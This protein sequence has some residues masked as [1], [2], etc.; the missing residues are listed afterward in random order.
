M[1]VSVANT[2]VHLIYI[3][4]FVTKSSQT[5]LVVSVKQVVDT[6]QTIADK[7]SDSE[8]GTNDNDSNDRIEWCDLRFFNLLTA[9]NCLQLVCSGGQGAIMCN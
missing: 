8:V 2:V 5:V 1:S 9:A 4:N 6:C 3:S 7:S